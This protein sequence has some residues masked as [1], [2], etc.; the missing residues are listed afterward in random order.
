MLKKIIYSLFV[1]II[2]IIFGFFLLE[3]YFEYKEKKN[4]K[5]RNVYKNL[6]ASPLIYHS[7]VGWT[8]KK[9]F[10]YDVPIKNENEKI[11]SK[12]TNN[13]GLA[14]SYN[15]NLDENKYNIFKEYSSTRLP[16]VTS[17]AWFYQ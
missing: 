1:F 6:E 13:L 10:Q 11:I 12:K 2:L 8:L 15:V 17:K 4:Y 7:I 14:S 16:A 5:N 3:N 9:N